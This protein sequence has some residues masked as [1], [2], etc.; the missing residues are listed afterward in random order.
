MEYTGMIY[1][2]QNNI[3]QKVYVGQT[4]RDIDTRF[5]EHCRRSSKCRKLSN[6]INKYGKNN[7]SIIVLKQIE[8]KDFNSLMGELNYWEK[9][10]IHLYDS[11]NK[12]YNCT[13]E[14]SYAHLDT[15]IKMSESMI[16]AKAK[17]I[18]QYNLDGSFV[19]C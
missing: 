15:P 8:S 10:Y 5:K 11:I 19:R 13:D 6:S 17:I 16:Q 9:Y 2:I 4:T 18:Y 1:L 7:F 14:T 3:T 12:G